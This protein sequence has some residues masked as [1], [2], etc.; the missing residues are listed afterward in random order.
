MPGE[1]P[2]PRPRVFYGRDKS[3]D[4][5]VGLAQRLTPIA[6]IGAGGIGKT[7]V[8]LAALHDRRITR[9]F[10]RNRLFIRCDEFPPSYAHFLRRLSSAIGAGI[11]NPDNLSSLRRFLSSKQMV[12][13]LDNAESVLDPGGRGARE[14]YAAVDEL[15]KFSNICLWITSRISI[16][17][18]DCKVIEVPTLS[19]GAAQDAFYRIYGHNKRS[20]SI[21]DVLGQLD[22]HPLSITLLATVARHNQ[23]D[24]SR[25]VMEWS[26]RRTGVL[27]TQHSPSLATAI[28]LSLASP[29]FRRLGPNARPLLEVAAFLPQGVN[30]N[31]IRWLFPTVPN[32]QKM[33]DRFCIL[34]L[35]YRN[36][37]FITMLAPLRDHL[38]PK[39]PASSPLLNTTKECYFTRLSGD[40][41][42]GKPGFEEARWITTEDVNLEHLLDFF[43]TVDPNSQSVWDA[44]AKFMAQ[45]YWHKPRLVTL[46]PKIEAL[47]DNHPSKPQCLW[48]LSQ[49]FE[50]VGNFVESEQLLSHT[51]KLW[52]KQGDY[53]QAAR[54][55]NDLSRTNRRI[56]LEREGIRQAREASEIFGR[57]GK[58]VEQASCLISLAFLLRDD[59]QFDAAEEAGS[60]AIDLLPAEG[61]EFKVCQ[62]HRILGNIY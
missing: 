26:K 56:G 7:S 20:G 29:M 36:N 9:W 52:R 15:T 38:R 21:N 4:K 14:I 43:T 23:W 17:P 13:V 25:L 5:I 50:S 19:T 3:I 40:I 61:E 28:G 8:I 2:L 37:G 51:L 30:E 10:G 46:G 41:T 1:P 58:V 57:L 62:A 18:P 11:E 48:D 39:N 42:P 27:R 45:L 31:H 12:I 6:L 24:S 47:S 34:S 33:L 35:T 60:R 54:T 53:F 59:G 44:C 55:L 16:I 22:N 49:L 32:V